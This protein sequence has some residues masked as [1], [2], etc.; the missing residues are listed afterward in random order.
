MIDLMDSQYRPTL[1]EI[2]AYV[3]AGAFDALCAELKARYAARET[4]A[5]SRCSMAPGW[6]VKFQKAGRSL[7]TLYP[8]EG[9]FTALV[10]IGQKEKARAEAVLA[11]GCAELAGLYRATKEGNGQRWLMIDLQDCDALYRDTLRLIALRRGIG[12]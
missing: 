4:V 11:D 1:E 3:R 7:C 2:S 10:V 5:F 12:A 6:N 8:K 9:W